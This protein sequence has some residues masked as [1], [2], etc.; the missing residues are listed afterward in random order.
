MISALLGI[1]GT[2]LD[3]IEE[4]SKANIKFK[5][6]RL[7]P[8]GKPK[9]NMSFEKID[10]DEWLNESWEESKIYKQFEKTKFLFIIFE[11]KE[12]LKENSKRELYFK[13]FKLWNMPEEIINSKVKELWDEV[14]KITREG[15]QIEYKKHGKRVRETNNF[16][17]L[18]FNGVTH[19]RSKAK[20]GNDK[21]ILPD[22]QKIT[23]QCY[24][25][26]RNYVGEILK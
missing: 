7:E 17:K 8:N 23:K 18:N 9:E 16:P 13:G 19:V 25:L 12:T 20:D 24:W 22:G 4:F 26:N 1:K 6:V 3:K 2:N 14:R 21:V 10:F 15:V 11:Y 5:T